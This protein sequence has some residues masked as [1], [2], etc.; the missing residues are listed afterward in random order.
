MSEPATDSSRAPFVRARSL[1][2]RFAARAAIRARG[3]GEVLAVD[4]VSLAI[5]RGET[6]GLV[7]ESGC[8]K[9]TLARVLLGLLRPASGK[10]EIDGRDIFA[11][12]RRELRRWRRDLQIVQQDPFGSLDPRWRIG[13]IVGEGLAI[14]RI[15]TSGERRQRVVETLQRCGLPAAALDRFPHEFSGGQRQRIGIAR[16]LALR[17]EFIIWDEPVSALDV[18]VQSQIIQLLL[19]LKEEYGLT[20]LLIAHD[21]SIVERVCDRVAVMYLGRIVEAAGAERVFRRPVHPYTQALLASIPAG[22]P[23]RRR[24]GAAAGDV[25]SPLAPPPGCR[26]HPRCPLAMEVCRR[27][28]PALLDRSGHR[29]ACHLAA[30]SPH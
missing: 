24:R 25:P 4:G 13:A 9:T 30:G 5:E 27:E 11:M 21:L 17:P 10:V 8:G 26:Y 3:R 12:S 6:L 22:R 20:Y 15:G 2:V 14:H 23:G 19:E 1:E 16:A 7:G 18:S 29:V 28:P